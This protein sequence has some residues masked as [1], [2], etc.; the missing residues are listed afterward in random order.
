MPLSKACSWDLCPGQGG[1]CSLLSSYGK[2]MVQ[3]EG[4]NKNK[5]L[6]LTW[7]SMAPV[8]SRVTRLV[9]SF[10][11]SVLVM[12][13]ERAR[14]VR[15]VMPEAWSM[16]RCGASH[17]LQWQMPKASLL[18]LVSCHRSSA[19]LG[20]PR[21]QLRA[22]DSSRKAG[23]ACSRCTLSS[24]RIRQVDGSQMHFHASQPSF[25][26]KACSRCTLSAARTHQVDWSPM[27]FQASQ[28][29]STGSTSRTGEEA[30]EEAVA[31]LHGRH[32]PGDDRHKF[33]SILYH[34]SR[35]SG[36]PTLH[37][38]MQSWHYSL[39][40]TY[41]RSYSKRSGAIDESRMPLCAFIAPDCL[42]QSQPNMPDIMGAM[43]CQDHSQHIFIR[44]RSLSYLA[45]A[46]EGW[47]PLSCTADLS[48]LYR[49]TQR[50]PCTLKAS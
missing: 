14:W 7:A 32:I 36:A 38:R 10:M 28:T 35:P 8:R 25:T 5:G 12:W 6:V 33:V 31:A 23:K 46:A 11:P 45:H 1:G 13:Q 26:G 3:N 50:R 41:R 42:L 44:W 37:Q 49:V 22:R 2:V 16:S 27:H 24:A 9:S 29:C 40:S 4:E 34:L 20:S 39:G 43:Q 30:M 15:L 48:M 18:R 19:C 21:N 47:S 17:W